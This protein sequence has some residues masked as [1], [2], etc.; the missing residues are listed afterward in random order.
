MLTANVDVKDGLVNGA[1]GEVVH[2]V[3]GSDNAVTKVLVKFDNPS[4]GHNASQC[5]PYNL[6]CDNAV[7]INW[8]EAVFLAQGKKGSEV[9]RVQFPLTLSW[10]T[11]IHKVQG[12]TLDEIVVDMSGRFSPGQ[13]YVAL[14]RIKRLAGL[15]ILNYNAGAIKR[16][17]MQF[18]KK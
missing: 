2:I 5:N 16:Q 17:V 18:T 4:V 8:H 7:V 11:T 10:A 13:A 1:I 3:T 9:T 12:V 15:H 14:S 6:I